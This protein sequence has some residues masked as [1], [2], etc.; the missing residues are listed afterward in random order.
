MYRVTDISY[1]KAGRFIVKIGWKTDGEAWAFMSL[2]SH[3]MK[4][5]TEVEHTT[6]DVEDADIPVYLYPAALS[7]APDKTK[8]IAILH[9]DGNRW[10]S[11]E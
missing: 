9:L 11:G 8:E 2:V 3:L 5:M 4:E 10:W 1:Y 7:K 6:E